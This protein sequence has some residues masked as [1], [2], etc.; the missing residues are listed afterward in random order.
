PDMPA[1]QRPMSFYALMAVGCIVAGVGTFFLLGRRHD[2][3]NNTQGTPQVVETPQASATQSA[4]TIPAVLPTPAPTPVPTPAASAS[5]ASTQAMMELQL[6]AVPTTAQIF[7]DG[8]RI[9]TN[10]WTGKVP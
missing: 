7:V 5:A 6:T 9:P 1:A 3:M 8:A 10:P 2:A 4:E